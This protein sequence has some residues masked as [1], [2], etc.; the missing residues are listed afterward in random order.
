ML[1]TVGLATLAVS[2]VDAHGYVSNP[3]PRCQTIP[4]H[5]MFSIGCQSDGYQFADCRDG[6]MV[7]PVQVTW[8]EGQEIDVDVFMTAF[9]GGWHGGFRF[10]FLFMCTF[11]FCYH[12]ALPFFCALYDC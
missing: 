10:F 11:E 3:K 4:G 5:P 8:V 1:A 7:G 9:H 12:S 2:V 6:E